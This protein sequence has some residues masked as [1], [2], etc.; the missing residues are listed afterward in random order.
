[1]TTIQDFFDEKIKLPSP[2]AIALKILEAVRKDENSFDELAEII[3][4]DPALTVR[5]LKIANSSLYGF[6]ARE[7]R[8]HPDRYE[9]DNF[10]KIP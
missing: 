2:P 7:V 6:P 9:L 10:P 5:I 8:L 3:S 1:M 4:A